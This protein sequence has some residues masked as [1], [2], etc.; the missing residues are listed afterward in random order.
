MRRCTSECAQGQPWS[1]VCP[2][3][4]TH[5]WKAILTMAFAI[6]LLALWCCYIAV[7]NGVVQAFLAKIVWC[8][9]SLSTLFM[10]PKVKSY[11]S[12]YVYYYCLTILINCSYVWFLS[13]Q[14]S[15]L[16][17]RECRSMRLPRTLANTGTHHCCREYV[18]FAHFKWQR[19]FI[20]D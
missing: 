2:T 20:I 12:T 7:L 11:K 19:Y 13:W 15:K 4:N 8:W 14:A 18:Q 16:W 9:G 17:Q 10:S 3:L 5:S 6:N 1:I